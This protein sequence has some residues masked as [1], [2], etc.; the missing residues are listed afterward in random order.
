MGC[1]LADY[2]LHQEKQK[3]MIS[4]ARW[5]GQCLEYLGYTYNFDVCINAWEKRKDGLGINRMWTRYTSLLSRKTDFMKKQSVRKSN[6]KMTVFPVMMP[7]QKRQKSSISSQGL[8][9]G[10]NFIHAINLS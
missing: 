4:D 2:L 10:H 7:H 6:S 9:L 8:I 1:F 5:Q 3:N